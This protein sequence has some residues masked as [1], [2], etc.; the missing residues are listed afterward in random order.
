MIIVA[1]EEE[2]SGPKTGKVTQEDTSHNP[3]KTK[4]KA[5][6]HP[7]PKAEILKMPLNKTVGRTVQLSLKML[8]KRGNRNGMPI[9]Q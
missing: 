2:D 4:V 8:D 7:K 5:E 3:L 1:M 6:P 9:T